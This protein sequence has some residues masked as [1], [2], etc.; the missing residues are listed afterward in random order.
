MKRIY[1]TAAAA[2]ALVLIDGLFLSAFSAVTPSLFSVAILVAALHPGKTGWILS[3]WCGL[4][5]DLMSLHLFGAYVVISVGMFVVARAIIRRGLEM[6]RF[7]NIGI[8]TLA[9]VGVQFGGQLAMRM[10]DG[11]LGESAPLLFQYAAW[12]AVF[13]VLVAFFILRGLRSIIGV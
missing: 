11:W 6:S 13:T 12:Q 9:V 8:V 4:L 2:T 10:T 7:V 3:L 5:L 1:A